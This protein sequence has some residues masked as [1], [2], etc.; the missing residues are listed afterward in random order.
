MLNSKLI[1]NIIFPIANNLYHIFY[2]KDS[3]YP[4]EEYF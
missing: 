3:F 1:I 2:H 4:L